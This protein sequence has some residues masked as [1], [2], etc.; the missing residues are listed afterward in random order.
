MAAKVKRTRRYDATR[1]QETAQR[2]R[3]AIIDAAT[4][5]FVR[6]GFAGA[7]IS[8]I[9]ADAERVGGDGVQGRSATRSAWY[10]RSGTRRSPVTGPSTPS[11]GPI[12]CSRASA[13]R[14]T[15][16][17]D[18][19]FWPWRW[20]REWRPCCCWYARRPRAIRNWRRLH[21]EMDAARLTRM[22]HNAKTLLKGGHLR[23]GLTLE[24][25][26]DVLWTYSS[27]E[28]YELLVLRRELVRPTI[29]SVHRRRHDRRAAAVTTEDPRRALR[30]RE[31]NRRGKT[32]SGA[33]RS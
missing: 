28:L 33:T 19:V 32:T 8:R 16:S 12:A 26:T 11:A 9:A 15:P 21:E 13:I 7:T 29:W 14:A 27:P 23:P 20:R 4:A 17:G 10:A 31:A 3:A 6:E 18:G 25:A 30:G 1:R 24:A 5:L 22:T 2:R